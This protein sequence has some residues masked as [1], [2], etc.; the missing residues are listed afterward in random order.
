MTDEE[1]R[2]VRNDHYWDAH[3]VQ[4]GTLSLQFS[5]DFDAVTAAFNTGELNWVRGGMNLAAV[6][7]T[8]NIVVNPQFATTYYQFSARTA[9]FDDARVRRALA[10]LLPWDEIRS[11]EYHYVPATTLVPAIPYYPEVEGITATDREEA[12]G[13]LD[14]AGFPNGSGLPSFAI[15]TP[16]GP[17]NERISALMVAAWKSELGLDV[18][19]ET[20]LYPEYF[21]LV[22][23][24]RFVMSTISWIGDFADPLTFL[25]MWTT[26]S[27]LNNSRYS[28]LEFDALVGRAIGETGSA[29]YETLAEAERLLLW[30]AVVLPINHSPSINLV[31][32]DLVDGWH[33]NPLDIHPF[34]FLSFA[35]GEPVPNV[36]WAAR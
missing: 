36:A 17:E 22:D 21:D 29:R 30:G 33:P 12:L 19:A 14:E 10:L 1:M 24:E 23:S 6:E 9:P 4:I 34:K 31:N 2:L 7:R 32:L 20:V 11:E 35:S 3:N 15:T 16:G 27:N 13:L 28:N 25:D 5:D 26:D 18:T 8:A